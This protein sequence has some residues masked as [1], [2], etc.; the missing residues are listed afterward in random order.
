MNLD[1]K[2]GRHFRLWEAVRS[3]VA[4]RLGIRNVPAPSDLKAIRWTAMNLMDPIRDR[5]GGMRVGSWYR[6]PLLNAAIPGSSGNSAHVWGG[7]I[8]FEPIDKRVKLKTI[9]EWIANESA[10]PFDQ[11]IYEYGEWVHV[12]ASRFDVY[13]EGR[14]ARKEVLMKFAGSGYQAYDPSD[15]R[16]R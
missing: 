16:V 12:G 7:A 14:R 11:A 10:L 8:D 13:G 2:V 4:A 3:D 15:P 5:F 6:S 1:E 9:V